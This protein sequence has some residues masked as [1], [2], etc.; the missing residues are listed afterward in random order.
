MS[1]NRTNK[2]K[3][4]M[5]DDNTTN[6]N[7]SKSQKRLIIVTGDKGG[8]GKST[9]ARALFQLYINKSL[10]CVT[11]E[12]DLR[13]PQLERYFKK[14]YRPIIRYIDIFHRGGADDLLINLTLFYVKI[15]LQKVW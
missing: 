9:F 5:S 14:D 8:V 1:Q 7:N 3:K 10:P 4:V 2:G 13:N 12:A 6:S 15:C 11:Y